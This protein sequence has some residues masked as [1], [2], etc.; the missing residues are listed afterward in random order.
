MC[1]TDIPKWATL[2]L[3][4]WYY[5]RRGIFLPSLNPLPSCI[6][7]LQ[8]K[9]GLE[10]CCFGNIGP[11]CFYHACRLGSASSVQLGG[12]ASGTRYIL[13]Q[14][15]LQ[16]CP[17]DVIAV[18]CVFCVISVNC[19]GPASRSAKEPRCADSLSG[20]SESDSYH[21]VQQNVHY[22]AVAAATTNVKDS[23]WF[24]S[25]HIT[26]DSHDVWALSTMA[27]LAC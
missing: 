8:G 25:N 7:I 1:V 26:Y 13:K 22:S 11:L 5:E 21:N 19:I 20:E 18:Q 15:T 23:A 3:E 12:S 10:A 14:L 2:R 4:G 27:V 24:D 6:P 9:L 17:H 16:I